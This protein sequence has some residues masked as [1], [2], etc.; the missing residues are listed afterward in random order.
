MVSKP[1]Y[2]A[3]I[4]LVLVGLACRAVSPQAGVPETGR[5]SG[6]QIFQQM[7]CAECHEGAAGI[8]APSL[9]GVYGGEVKFEN[10]ETAT[11]DVDYL[12]ESITSP[13]ARIVQGYKP[14]MPNFQD[15]LSDEEL[16]A[17]IEY[18]KSLADE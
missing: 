9:R 12:R 15:R 2:F 3:L 6:E 1:V 17:L 7:G 4:V 11:A 5:D 14:V 10:G 16:D 13:E 8:V 18:I